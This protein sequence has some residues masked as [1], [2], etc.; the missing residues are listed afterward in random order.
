MAARAWSRGAE[1]LGPNRADLDAA[2]TLKSINGELA[3]WEVE[4][5]FACGTYLRV[6]APTASPADDDLT[7]LQTRLAQRAGST[8][9]RR[10]DCR[11]ALGHA[12]ATAQRRLYSHAR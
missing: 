10:A 1:I 3:G 4:L 8:T 9:A 12:A 7:R 11:P 2:S 6:Y 5:E